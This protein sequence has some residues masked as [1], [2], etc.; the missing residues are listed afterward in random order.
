[1][2][3]LWRTLRANL[4]KDDLFVR[5]LFLVLGSSLAAAGI[6]GLL[7]L[8]GHDMR[9]QPSWA[10]WLSACLLS[11]L[12]GWGLLLA[13]RSFAPRESKV[14]DL[15]ERFFPDAFDEST[16]LFM[17]VFCLPALLLTYL[18][19]WLGVQGE[20]APDDPNRRH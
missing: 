4:S 20:P 11:I 12:L 19:R 3:D 14:A 10:I 8:G 7:W 5:V 13:A 16:L 17:A 2:K 1:M 6:Y 9:D 18:L 15:A